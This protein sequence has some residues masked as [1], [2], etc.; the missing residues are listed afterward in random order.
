MWT[1]GRA[2]RGLLVMGMVVALLPVAPA[3]AAP[4][5]RGSIGD[6]VWDDVDG[7]G[8]SD[9]GESGIAGVT[10]WLFD[11]SG[12]TLLDTVSTGATGAFDFKKLPAGGYLVD[13]DETTLPAGAV[14]TTGNEPLVV[15]L[16]DGEDFNGA[17]F[18]YQIT[19]GGTGSVGDL[20]WDDVDGDGLF[21]AGDS[22]LV[23]WMCGCG[24]V[25]VG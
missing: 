3:G 19:A 2:V 24:M 16:A 5:P 17:D 7:D 13:V 4:P 6:L 15:A 25:R 21:G 22:G 1:G 11:S 10:V 18:G 9:A 12:T 20:V 8:V 14:L 23:V